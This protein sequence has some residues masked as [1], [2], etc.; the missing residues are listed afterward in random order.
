MKED[1]SAFNKQ[2]E[3]QLQSFFLPQEIKN[4]YQIVECLKDG[5]DTWTLLVKEKTVGFIC[6]LKQ[7]RG[8][9]GELLKREYEILKELQEMGLR[10][11]PKPYC[12]I[13]NGEHRYFFREYIEGKSLYEIAQ[14]KPFSQKELCEIG[15]ELCEIVG[16]M[17]ELESPILHR[18]IKPENIIYTK[19][20]DC[21]LVDF[22]TARYYQPDGE[23]DTFVVG[24]KG[25]AAPEQYGWAQTDPRTD[26]Y[27]IGETLCYLASGTFETQKLKETLQNRSLCKIIKKATAFDPKKR[28]ATSQE[29][30]KAIQSCGA[31]RRSVGSR[32]ICAGAFA[33]LCLIF[34]AY[35]GKVLW[36]MGENVDKTQEE[37]ISGK[38]EFQ[39]PLVE[40]AV[41]KALG[42]TEETFITEE[43]LDQITELRIVGEEILTPEDTLEIRNWIY[44]NGKDQEESPQ[45]SIED[46]SDFSLMKN[47]E[48]L[49]LCRQKLRDLS[50]LGN[51]PL[52]N[53]NLHENKLIEISPLKEL[54]NLKNLFLGN[55]PC[56]NLEV[57]GECL[58]LE[59]LNLDAMVIK[60]LDFLE[61][62]DLEELSL[63][64]TRV[65]IGGI[66]KLKTQEHLKTLCKNSLNEED[67]AVLREMKQLYNLSCYH[68]YG[69]KD[70]KALEGME[71]LSFFV[72]RDGLVSLEGIDG[73]PSLKYLHIQGSNVS[74]LSPISGA[75]GLLHLGI[76]GISSI[77]SYCPVAEHPTLEEIYCDEQQREKILEEDPDTQLT[78]F[79]QQE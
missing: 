59:N 17:H 24:T 52:E 28:Y 54:P 20:G 25:T 19:T 41:R 29:L 65:A 44:V 73:L 49:V 32:G 60:N 63:L 53:L 48:T 23:R 69:L 72:V 15:E 1:F 31:K 26:V 36:Q 35:G 12:L 37:V 78:F 34:G 13:E 71:N 47:L 2:Y 11:I 5:E 45:G 22:G 58:R 51:L 66:E 61:F 46:L 67:A 43:M 30:K 6:V 3:K 74:D 76:Q 8:V 7:G 56:T 62:L 39:E 64:D 42:I 70:L 57:L 79:I 9:Y 16:Q 27:A 38:V 68:S 4:H 10:G 14:E 40:K 55:N 33:L 21:V 75:Y 18:D 50:P 77:E